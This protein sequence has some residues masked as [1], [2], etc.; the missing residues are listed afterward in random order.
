MTSFGKNM[1]QKYGKNKD[2]IK[3]KIKAFY[4]PRYLKE[5][6][7]VKMF[8]ENLHKNLLKCIPDS[9]LNLS[10]NFFFVLF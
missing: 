2:R 1:K 7:K 10:T 3:V 8:W 6:K 4:N 5:F 9:F